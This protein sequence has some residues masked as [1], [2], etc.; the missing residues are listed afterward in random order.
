ML[1]ILDILIPFSM[2]DAAGMTCHG[3]CEPSRRCWGPGDTNCVACANYRYPP[4][5]RCVPNC[6]EYK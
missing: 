5:W 2:S 1:D 6:E 4:L 3:E